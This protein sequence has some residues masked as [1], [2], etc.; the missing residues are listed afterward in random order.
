MDLKKNSQFPKFNFTFSYKK[1][2][3]KCGVNVLP[4]N[5]LTL[6]KGFN[7]CCLGKLWPNTA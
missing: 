5:T 6:S 4:I 3:W 7:K 2:L 1:S